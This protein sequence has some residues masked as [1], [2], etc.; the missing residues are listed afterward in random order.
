MRTCRAP[1]LVKTLGQTCHSHLPGGQPCLPRRAAHPALCA[2]RSAKVRRA[3]PRCARRSASCSA[4]LVWFRVLTKFDQQRG[5]ATQD[6][7]GHVERLLSKVRPPRARGAPASARAR[8]RPRLLLSG[9]ADTSPPAYQGAAGRFD[10]RRRAP[11]GARRRRK[12][13]KKAPRRPAAS[14]PR[15]APAARRH[16]GMPQDSMARLSCAQSATGAG[17]LRAADTI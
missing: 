5:P 15:A 14:P 9:R 3:R 16:R 11:G 12:G 13:Q 4:S 8:P 2:R 7:V 6:I 17:V 1:L 10:A